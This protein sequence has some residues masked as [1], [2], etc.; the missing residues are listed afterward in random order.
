MVVWWSTAISS[1]KVDDRAAHRP[2]HAVE[3]LD[4]GGDE[5]GQL[6]DVRRLDP[7]DDV[8][9]PGQARRLRDARQLPERRGYGGRLAAFGL[10]QDVS[11][12]HV[13]PIQPSQPIQPLSC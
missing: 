11:G 3:A 6:V 10:D 9:G 7:G 1:S 8:V 12:D 5:P 2:L 13:T 4:L